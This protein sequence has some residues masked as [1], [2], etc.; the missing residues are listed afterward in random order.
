MKKLYMLTLACT[1][2]C[3]ATT[4]AQ[5]TRYW[6]GAANGL[7]SSTSNWSADGVTTG[8]SVPNSA[9][10]IAIFDQGAPTVEVSGSVQLL[11]LVVTN[12]VTAKITATANTSFQL[13]GTTTTNYALRIDGG[14]RLES[15]NAPNAGFISTFANNAK[16][17][18]NGTWYFGAT[19]AGTG[20]S[21]YSLPAATGQG[22]RLDVNGTMILGLGSVPH[23][24]ASA[25]GYCFFN[26]GS[27]CRV[28]RDGGGT[29]VATWASTST[30]NIV[31][32]TG[33]LTAINTV[34]PYTIGN[35][36]FNCPSLGADLTWALQPGLNIG[37]HFQVLNTNNR[38]VTLGFGGNLGANILY[39]VT[40]NFELGGTSVVTLGNS[41]PG[42]DASWILQVNGSYSQTGGTFN[43]RDAAVS[44][45]TYP[46]ELRVKGNFTQTAGTF[47]APATANPP[48]EIYAV[49]LNGNSLQTISIS[50]GTI[51]NANNV[52][53]LRMNNVNGAVLAAPLSVGRLSWATTNKG[54]ISSGSN[55]LMINNTANDA[56]TVNGAGSNAFVAG[57]VGRRTTAAAAHTLPTGATVY[58]PVDIIPNA[59][60]LSS[61]SGQYVSGSYGVTAVSTPLYK[62]SNAEYWNI[63]KV[64]GS[65]AAVKLTVSG[66]VPG[67]FGPDKL[68]VAHFNTV[69]NKWESVKGLTG[70][71]LTPGNSTTGTVTSDVLSSF[72]PF[73]FGVVPGSPLPVYLLS[74]NAKKV[75][76]TAAKLD[77]NITAS[78]NPDRFEVLRSEDGS[79]FTAVGTVKAATQQ[80]TFTFQDNQLPKKTTYYQLR[81]IDQQGVVMM[82]KIVTVFNNGEGWLINSMM[83]TLVTSQA[84]LN[85]SA[86][87]RANIRLAVTDMYGR[88]VHQQQ[89]ALSA[90]SQ[91]VWLN[92]SALPAGAYQV[93]GILDN[94]AKTS[95]I[96]FV[97]Q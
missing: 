52:V 45:A 81:M 65:D 88:I 6:R 40:G 57:L 78:S 64:S 55:L 77:W 38:N 32:N 73:T 49:E 87:S 16:G 51:D 30:I 93:T 89:S 59:A 85:I 74:F 46:T 7:W 44:L 39:T 26:G 17:L 5:T 69:D 80:L 63:S 75:S 18:V 72:S 71:E 12:N 15:I 96:R 29:P 3:I 2:C 41:N 22:N 10:S 92:L 33:T 82:S 61:Y 37:G 90:G 48:S 19:G 76:N 68:V 97:K 84:K 4:H 79:N 31:G 53:T 60:T 36:V 1:L 83:P 11:S 20:G 9:T 27:E 42:A 62:V 35:L 58:R 86:S 8:A 66:A 21:A 91:D 50:S 70:T 34:S 67:A 23:T 95:S 94:G 24:L 13:V 25:A 56:L 14:S 54:K 43:L 47:G 28:E